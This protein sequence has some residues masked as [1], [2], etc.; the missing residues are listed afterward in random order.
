V[1]SAVWPLVVRPFGCDISAEE[2]YRVPD[3]RLCAP[4]T[5]VRDRN[6]DL[7]TPLCESDVGHAELSSELG[8]GLGP[9][10]IVEALS[11]QG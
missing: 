5:P 8:H 3:R 11:G 10:E 2:A 7:S 6:V 1:G 9:D 4:V